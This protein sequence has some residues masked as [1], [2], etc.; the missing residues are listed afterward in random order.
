VIARSGGEQADGVG[1]EGLRR[2]RFGAEQVGALAVAGAI[3]LTYLF[4]E[5]NL[6]PAE[7]RPSTRLAFPVRLREEFA[8]LAGAPV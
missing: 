2:Q 6:K 8:L 7:H 5:R 3:A 1:R 4:Y